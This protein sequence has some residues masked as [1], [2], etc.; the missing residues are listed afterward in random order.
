MILAEENTMEFMKELNISFA[1]ALT[2][3][4]SLDRGLRIV[5]SVKGSG[6]FIRPNAKG[7]NFGISFVEAVRGKYCQDVVEQQEKKEGGNQFYQSSG[8]FEIE[9]VL[10]SQKGK[11]RELEALREIGLE[12]EGVNCAGSEVEL[13]KLASE[14]LSKIYFDLFRKLILMQLGQI[15]EF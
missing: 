13:S 11:G 4:G 5:I 14:L 7:L 15:F 9:V 2:L 10:K 8:N 6:S 1:R 12:N 3:F